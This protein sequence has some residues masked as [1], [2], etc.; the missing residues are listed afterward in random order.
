MKQ[1]RTLIYLDVAFSAQGSSNAL[2][3]TDPRVWN[4]TVQTP[5]PSVKLIVR[6]LSF[7]THPD[8]CANDF[9]ESVGALLY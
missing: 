1:V 7:A 5:A 4:K 9:L 6:D 2:Q 8:N 3:I